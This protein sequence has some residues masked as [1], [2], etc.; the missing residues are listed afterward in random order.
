MKHVRRWYRA[1]CAKHGPRRWYLAFCARFGPCH[2]TISAWL[3]KR[4]REGW[5]H[6]L[7]ERV[8]DFCLVWR[9]DVDHFRT[10]FENETRSRT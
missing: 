10:C 6:L 1:F 4:E 9:G 7:R 5:G 3:W 2:L 8:D